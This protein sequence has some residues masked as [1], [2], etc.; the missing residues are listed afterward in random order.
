MTGTD[1]DRKTKRRGR[2]RRPRSVASAGAGDKQC[3]YQTDPAVGGS[4]HPAHYFEQRSEF[5]IAA[6]ETR[7]NHPSRRVHPPHEFDTSDR[8][9]TLRS[10]GTGC[11]D[12][13]QSSREGFDSV[14]G[15][16]GSGGVE[17]H[18]PFGLD[19]CDLGAVEVVVF[20][21]HGNERI[22]V[23]GGQIG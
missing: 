6:A 3:D 21:E 4:I 10:S 23:G 5:A 2:V 15:E 20:V 9:R 19:G 13:P 16:D 7:R 17:R 22:D 12:S 11:G 14:L 18:V 8:W 1:E